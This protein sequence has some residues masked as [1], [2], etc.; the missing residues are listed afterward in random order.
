MTSKTRPSHIYL[1]PELCKCLDDA[2]VSPTADVDPYKSDVFTF[3]MVMMEA[4]L[5]KYLDDCYREDNT[6]INWET[7]RY[8]LDQIG[9]SYSL[10]L[11]QMI[12]RLVS[13]FPK[14]PDWLELKQFMKDDGETQTQHTKSQPSNPI[15]YTG[16]ASNPRSPK[17]PHHLGGVPYR[18]VSQIPVS[19]ASPK[20]VTDY[21][22]STRPPIGVNQPIVHMG[23]PPVVVSQSYTG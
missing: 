9:Q 11:K 18:P 16:L 15:Q 14:R 13:D 20:Y 12:E 19:Q 3:G 17:D 23:P 22:S 7:I 21:V 8:Y 5:L 10:D 1:S 4:A 2:E 6:K